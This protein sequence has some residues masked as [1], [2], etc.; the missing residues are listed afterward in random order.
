MATEIAVVREGWSLPA[1]PRGVNE[2]VFIPGATYARRLE[3]GWSKQAPDGVYQVVGTMAKATF[4]RLAKISFGYRAL[5]GA[6]RVQGRAGGAAARAARSASTRNH[7]AA[8]LIMPSKVVADAF[9][10]RLY[11]MAEPCE[12][13]ARRS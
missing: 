4:N 6:G 5:V 2:F 9:E 7:C 8:E 10:A 13:S 11:G 3:R 1:L 12:L